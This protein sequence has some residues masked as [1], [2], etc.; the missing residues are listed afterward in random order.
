MSQS[1]LMHLLELRLVLLR[2]TFCMLLSFFALVYWANDIYS[3]VAAPLLRVLPEAMHMIA[4]DLIS[5]VFA[6]FKLTLFVACLLSVPYILWQIGRFIMPGLYDHEKYLLCILLC[7]GTFLFYAGMVFSY[8]VVLPVIVGFMLDVLPE[9]VH[10]TTD[11]Q[12]YLS[13]VMKLLLG[14]GMAFEVPVVVVGLC[15]AGITNVDRLKQKRA[16]V[17]VGA[18][19]F[20]MLLTPPDVFSQCLLAIPMLFLFELGLFLA[21]RLKISVPDKPSTTA[22]QNK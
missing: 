17:I 6:P 5:P 7:L 13:F 11:I 21:T 22:V 16:Y 19:V 9:G 8:A 12:L 3:L 4:I 1:L 14:F 2:C 15:C 18:F 20:A 10:L